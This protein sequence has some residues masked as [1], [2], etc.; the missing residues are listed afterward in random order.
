MDACSPTAKNSGKIFLIDSAF[1]SVKEN[2]RNIQ[3]FN[4]S[5]NIIVIDKKGISD[6]DILNL[7]EGMS[8][9]NYLQAKAFIYITDKKLTWG[10]SDARSVNTFPVFEVSRTALPEKIK[11]ASFSVN[12]KYTPS[13][14][15]QNVVGFIKGKIKPDSFFV[16][17]AH[18]DH[19]GMMG[20]KVLFPGAHDNASGVAMSMDLMKY[21]ANPEHAPDYSMVFI[22]TSAEEMGILGSE[23]FCSHPLFDLSKIKFLLNL[24]MMSTG[25]DGIMLVNGGVFTNEYDKMVK[26]N[27]AHNYV[28]TISKRGEAK[29]SDHWYFYKK[30]VKCFFIYT[31]GGKTEYH[32]INDKA[33]NL[34]MTEYEDIF[35]LLLDFVKSFN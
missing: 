22:A 19:L 29:N 17:T 30:G 32:N 10:L 11:K 2:L 24:D 14:Q 4:F 18:Y 1:L 8:T 5:K 20:N 3:D 13:Y 12:S 35:K 34:P 21:Y 31:L 23:Y 7:L 27:T 26:L 6:K 25:D 33:A 15:T 9:T 16:F 28:K